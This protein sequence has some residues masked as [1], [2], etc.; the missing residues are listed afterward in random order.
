MIERKTL[1]RAILTLLI[2]SQLVGVPVTFSQE[3]DPPLFQ[4]YDCQI[5]FDGIAFVGSRPVLAYAQEPRTFRVSHGPNGLTVNS[6]TGIP[7]WRSPVG[8]EHVVRIAV[9]T[10][11]GTD[12][13]EWILHVLPNDIPNVEILQGDYIDVVVPQDIAQWF[14]TYS[15]MPHLDM[16]YR[17]MRMVMGTEVIHGKQIFRYNPDGGTHNGNPATGGPAFWSTDPIR[18]WNLGAL[19]HEVGHNFLGN[20]I[21][22][23]ADDNWAQPYIHHLTA[24]LQFAIWYRALDDPSFFGLS[25]QAL[26]NYRF[27]VDERKAIY[28]KRTTAYRDWINS[29]GNAET[30]LQQDS[31]DPYGVWSWITLDLLDQYG[32]AAIEKSLGCFRPDGF[33]MSTEIIQTA[34]TPLQKNTL[35][36]CTVSCGTG[37]DMRTFFE[38][39]GFQVDQEYYDAIFPLVQSVADNLPNE[40]WGD[41]I[42]NTEGTSEYRRLCWKTDKLQASRM[43]RQH[44]AYLVSITTPE[45]ENWVL[46]RFEQRGTYWLGL[47]YEQGL[48]G[49]LWASG[50]P[51]EYTNWQTG[52]PKPND[53]KTA[54]CGYWYRKPGWAVC[55]PVDYNFSVILERDRANVDSNDE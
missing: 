36:I 1:F 24:F 15:V 41:W 31:T 33:G 28:F 16:A 23:I 39:R 14:Q 44:G 49:P 30:Y 17:Y 3:S 40:S 50:E 55:S 48:L 20:K 52:H 13:V 29:G 19:Y 38:E 27:Y 51:V 9:D 8:T 4:P 5:A 11:G 47:S 45:E 21:P 10:P 2:F 32:A 26:E 6:H 25:G 42:S 54:V 7:L 53:Q 43:A 12:E 35:L 46:N 37:T 18:G 22:M 34:E